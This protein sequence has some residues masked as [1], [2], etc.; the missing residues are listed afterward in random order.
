[1]TPLWSSGTHAHTLVPTSNAA[2][3]VA[4]T[5]GFASADRTGLL[6]ERA[7]A[8]RDRGRA[9]WIAWRT[10]WTAQNSGGSSTAAACGRGARER[11]AGSGHRRRPCPPQIWPPCCSRATSGT[12]STSRRAPRTTGS[13]SP[14]VTPR[15][16][17][18][19]CSAPPA[20]S[21][22]RSS[23]PTGSSAAGSRA[24]HAVASVGRRGNRLARPGA[25]DRGRD[26]ARREAAR[27]PA[28]PGLGHLRRQRD[29]RGLDVGG[30]RAR[31]L[32]R[33]RQPDGDH[34]A[35]SSASGRDH[36]RLGPVLAGPPAPFGCRDRDRRPRRRADR[37]RL[38]EA[39]S[40]TRKPTAIV[41]KTLKGKG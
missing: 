37:C 14:R 3:S 29:G 15:R 40:T 6:N 27:P 20:C 21:R 8:P 23:A 31:R 22:R 26:G 19:A 10:R 32:L 1:M 39:E 36:A 34:R 11:K 16:S 28:V 24:P 12:T 2:F 38:P 5:T 41:A 17:S 35:S 9:A 25:A 18:T 30:R 4:S 7:L 33:A 13:S